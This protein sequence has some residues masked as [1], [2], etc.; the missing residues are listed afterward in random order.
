LLSRYPDVTIVCHYSTERFG[1]ELTLEALR[2]HPLVQ[3]ADGIFPGLYTPTTAIKI[4]AG[5]TTAIKIAAGPT[6]AMNVAAGA[7]GTTTWPSPP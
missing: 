7:K 5:P 6:S 2:A 1:S 4:A 3:L